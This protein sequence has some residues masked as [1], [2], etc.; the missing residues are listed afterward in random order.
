M[1]HSFIQDTQEI[2]R[3]TIQSKGLIRITGSGTKDWFGAELK[4]DPLS[5]KGYQGIINYQ[6]DELVITVKSGTSLKEV[7][8]ALEE[9]NQQFAFEPPYFGESATIGGMVC[10][11]LAGP[12]R[13]SAGS[14]RDFVLG[15]KIMDGQGQIMNFGGTVMKN[16]AGYDVSRLMPASLGT[17]ALLLDVS[18]KVLPKPAATATLTAQ[19]NQAEAIHLMNLLASQPWPLS[20]SAWQGEQMGQLHIRLN[21]AKAAVASAIHHFGNQYG[22]K[23]LNQTEAEQYWKDLKEQQLPWFKNSAETPLWRFAVAPTSKPL[24]LSGETLI[25]WHGGQRWWKGSIEPSTAKRIAQT[26]Q[27][28]ASLFRASDKTSAML[29]SLKDHPLTRPLVSI[30]D[31]LSKAFDPH[32]VFATGRLA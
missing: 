24:S 10:S 29:S 32:G 20:A 11:G 22:M 4:G 8:L 23:P 2:I 12:G 15:A 3:N 1:N 28:H 5:T 26:A 6:P 27:G 31:Q 7:E 18:I 9:K 16:V 13:V 14:L 17:L 21:G 19:I 25:E 30:Q